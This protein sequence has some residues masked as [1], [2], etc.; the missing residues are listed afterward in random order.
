MTTDT[1]LTDEQKAQFVTDITE[2][3]TDFVAPLLAVVESIEQ[4]VLQSP[5][6][7]ALRKK[8]AMVDY[9]EQHGGA[10]ISVLTSGEWEVCG[11][12]IYGVGASLAEA[13]DTAMEQK[14]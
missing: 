4:A 10:D 13:F 14:P 8:A 9:L 6:I 2:Y 11:G 3:G 12:E 5:E 1:V 7:Q